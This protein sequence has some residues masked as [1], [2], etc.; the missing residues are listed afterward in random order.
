MSAICRIG[1][2]PEHYNAPWQTALQAFEDPEY[3]FTWENVPQGT[4]AMLEALLGGKLD[5]A[6][7]LTE[8]AVARAVNKG[9]I[10]IIGTFVSTPLHWGIHTSGSAKN[11]SELNLSESVFGIS[12]YGSG[13]HIMAMI[14]AKQHNVTA[15]NFKVVDTM[16]G[17]AD[18]MKKGDIDL[19][20]WDIATA[21]LYAREN[22]WKCIGT[23]SGDWPAFVLATSSS[24]VSL[25]SAIYRCLNQVRN[26]AILLKEEQEFAVFFLCDKYKLTQ[27]QAADFL[28]SVS[29]TA[30]PDI[31][32]SALGRVQLALHEA[33]VI[34]KI[35][36]LDQIVDCVV[37][38][39]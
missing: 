8:G 11:I 34:E 10:K 28:E 2:V 1:G 25:R 6:L 23:V 32:G 7:V 37:L 38:D 27:E 35:A 24:D 26:H 9:D 19:F 12:R 3:A 33:G 16:A 15:P 30:A 29:W 39:N 14:L 17:A 18:A 4:G 36:P 20:L 13:S 22:V 21:D 31:S 5:V